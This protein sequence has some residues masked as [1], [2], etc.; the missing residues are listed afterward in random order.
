[1]NTFS[2]WYNYMEANTYNDEHLKYQIWG[3]QFP[4]KHIESLIT[5]MKD[6]TNQW[7][8]NVFTPGKSKPEMKI[9]KI[10]F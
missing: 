9:V 4:L 1:M 6:P 8:D 2:T 3:F 7:F 5:I 10:S